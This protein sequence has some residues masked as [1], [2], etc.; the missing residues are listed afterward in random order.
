MKKAIFLL[1]LLAVSADTTSQQL[2]AG[3]YHSFA[4]CG[5]GTV[6]GF[7]RNDYGQ[8]GIGNTDNQFAPVEVSTLTDIVQVEAGGYHSIFRS[9]SGNIWMTGSNAYGNFGNNSTSSVNTL[10]EFQSI[11]GIT[12]MDAGFGHSVFADVDGNVWT[13]GWGNQGQ[14]G[15][16]NFSN[17]LVP[18]QMSGVS[19]VINVEAGYWHTLMLKSDGTVWAAGSNNLGQ[20][21]QPSSTPYSSVPVQIPGLSD[22]VQISAG[23][24][25]SL[26]LNSQGQVFATGSN[27]NGQLG[28]GNN[29]TQYGVV[30]V[31]GLPVIAGV[32]AGNEHSFFRTPDGHLYGTGLGNF[33]QNGVGTNTTV[34]IQVASPDNV[35]AVAA[36]GDGNAGHSIFLTN[37]GVMWGCG[38]A[39]SGQ[40]G[41]N[42][43]YIAL[44]Q[45]I[46]AICGSFLPEAFFTANV[47]E[48]CIFPDPCFDFTNESSNATEFTWNFGH[49]SIPESNDPVF[50]SA[51]YGVGGTYTITLSATNDYGTSTYSMEVT[52]YDIPEVNF[53]ME[54]M[55]FCSGDD[56]VVLSGGTPEG[57]VYSGTGVSDGIFDPAQA[58]EGL[59][60]L[61][62]TAVNGSAC[63]ASDVVTVEVTPCLPPIADFDLS[64][65][66]VCILDSCVDVFN[67]SS[68][69]DSLFWDLPGTTLGSAAN[70]PFS[71][72]CF[73]TP[74]LHTISLTAYNAY[75]S[76]TFEINVLVH[77]VPQ[78]SLILE[79]DVL[80][81]NFANTLALSGGQPE[82]GVYSG[83][84]VAGNEIDGTESGSGLI[85]VSYTYTLFEECLATAVDTVTVD[86]CDYISDATSESFSIYPGANNG[87]V[88][89]D[90]RSSSWLNG[91]VRLIGSTGK[92][93]DVYRIDD[94]RMELQTVA[95]RGIYFIQIISP[96]G[97]MTTRR[98]I[99]Q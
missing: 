59:H 52:L 24:Y 44:P 27:P 92:L 86:I 6:K 37:A 33:G 66:V 74:G 71:Q 28:I 20:I 81:I 67:L 89:I 48:T 43:T 34:P 12:D 64:A 36:S 49:P 11:A 99:G 85:P 77:P 14:L 51:C 16:G 4:L 10:P 3:Y 91:S 26:F 42:G 83:P 25:Y 97:E 41:T 75:D 96:S 69:Y 7:G 88:I 93:I 29:I 47:T 58:G 80:C 82:G 94:T 32:T 1:A 55:I 30:S 65:A 90:F 8:L 35:I 5:D 78:V 22:I 9:A 61:V 73:D 21:G 23:S 18:V 76:A 60:Q 31:T 57:G 15:S 87:S 38:S 45:I 46:T 79:E 70:M 17:S 40:L 13:C 68:N 56:P 2:S 62:Y 19:D 84:G 50:A 95:A 63:S 98:I 72:L 39:G 53:A 54:D